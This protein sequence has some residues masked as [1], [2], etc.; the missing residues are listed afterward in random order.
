M[1]QRFWP[2]QAFNFGAFF[3]G[4]YGFV[5][6]FAPYV[7]LYFAGIGMTA[8]Q[9]GILMSLAQAMR[10]FGPNLWGWVADATQKR[11]RVMRFTAIGALLSFTG[12]FFGES[13]AYLFVLM[14][15]LNLFT[16]AQG[17][18]CEALMIGE[19]RG[20]LT[21]YGVIRLWGSV[22]YIVVV[23]TAG[24]LFDW[25]GIGMMPWVGLV[26]L[27]FVLFVSA[28]L[29]ETQPSAALQGKPSMRALL[30]RREI[31]AF[32]VSAC[33]M[34]ASHTALYVFFSLYMAQ[35][36][37]SNVVIGLMWTLGVL[38]EIAFFFYQ[39]PLFRKIG[40]QR[41]MLLSLAVAVARFVM[42]GVGADFLLLLLIA[43]AMHGITFG[44][45]HSSSVMLL[46]RWFSGPLQARGQALYVSV[47]YGLGGTLGGIGF[48]AIW[49]RFGPEA[50]YVGAAI[51]A[52]GGLV[53][54]M[55]SFRWHPVGV[56]ER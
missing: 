19:M 7:S 27:A 16:S 37:Y 50:V 35:R 54:A 43:Q 49:D 13:F 48:S 32:L 44:V 55:L 5:G 10:I 33:L 53:A 51:V 18:L 38:A 39:A 17:P 1:Q 8:V 52:L 11:V 30:R 15:A 2:T 14:I 40:V 23:M 36:G 29:R 26:M 34:I 46:Q 56:A 25:L 6:V 9:I 20:D 22:G 42:I 45:H 31:I 47:S 24:W 41:L 28:R 12:I 21:R 3:F 4:Y